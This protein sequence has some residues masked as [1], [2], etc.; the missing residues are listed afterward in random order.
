[1]AGHCGDEDVPLEGPELGVGARC[2]GGGARD[3]AQKRDLA[4][5][6]AATQ[7][8]RRS[9]LRFHPHLSSLDHVE[10]VARIALAEEDTAGGDTD[11]REIGSELLERNRW[12]RSEDRDVPEQREL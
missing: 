6:V 2:H 8:H 4:E 12:Q 7:R 3:I 5:V 10:A 11:V 9:A 1:M